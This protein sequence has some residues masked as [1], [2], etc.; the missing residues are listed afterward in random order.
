VEEVSVRESSLISPGVHA[1]LRV[2]RNVVRR[3]RRCVQRGGGPDLSR[4]TE[5]ALW[6]AHICTKW[7]HCVR[8]TTPCVRARAYAGAAHPPPATVMLSTWGRVPREVH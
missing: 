6:N 5:P 1:R 3:E 8:R 2:R 7:T 4:V